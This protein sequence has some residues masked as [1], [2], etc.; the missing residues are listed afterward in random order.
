MDRIP[1]NPD[2]ADDRPPKQWRLCVLISESLCR[3]ADWLGVA[4][5][6]ADG[7][8]DCIQLREKFLDGHELLDRVRRL[9]KMCRP[10]GISVIVN[11]RLDIALLGGADGVHLGQTDLPCA[12]TRRLVGRPARGGLIGIST[13]GLEEAEQALRDGADYCGI[14]PMFCTRTK[15]KDTIVGPVYLRR[16]LAWNRLPHLAI[17]GITPRNVRQLV[18]AGVKGVAVSAAVCGAQDP[19]AVVGQILARMP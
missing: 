10:R 14:G 18:D 17:G 3:S 6:A 12:E 11:D 19:T 9:I 4:R 13:S 15:D 1:C 16:Y 5:A 2:A 8:A 7:G